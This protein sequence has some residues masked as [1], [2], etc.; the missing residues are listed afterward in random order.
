MSMNSTENGNVKSELEGRD[1]KAIIKNVDSESAH[2]VGSKRAGSLTSGTAVS[3]DMQQ[4][5]VEVTSQAFEGNN[6][7]KD[8]AMV[9]K[10]EFDRLYGT[11]WHCVVGKK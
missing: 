5:A 11:T 10:K 6:L 4:K 3:E 9:I 8:I 1:L 7:E 2:R